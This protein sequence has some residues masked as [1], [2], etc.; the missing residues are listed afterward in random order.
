MSDDIGQSVR[1]RL[2]N[3]T[4]VMAIVKE[5]DKILADA[6][7]ATFQPPGVLVFVTGVTTY[8]DINSS[9]RCGPAQVEV[10]AYGRDRQESN[11]LAKAI[12]DSALA[13]D[14]SGQIHGM[15]WREVSLVAG[16]S[17]VIDRPTEGSDQWR[18]IT[19]QTFSI[20][21]NPI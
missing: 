15:D 8:E 3:T 14:L 18:R 5:P 19:Q 7:P 21:A 10:F 4:Q 13:A 2:A 1:D 20:W 9:S 11:A 17:E 6:M 16:P 12:R